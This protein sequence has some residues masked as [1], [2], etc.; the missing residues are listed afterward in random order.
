MADDI[1]TQCDGIVTSKCRNRR[2]TARAEALGRGAT[3]YQGP[4]CKWGHSGLRMVCNSGCIECARLRTSAWLERQKAEHPDKHKAR[5][6]AS[7]KRSYV[8]HPK[9]QTEKSKARE[10]AREAGETIFFCGACPVGHT[11]GWY[12][13]KGS[14]V[15]CERL[16]AK[17]K[18]PQ[19]REYLAANPDVYRHKNRTAL[20]RRRGAE[21]KHTKE[22]VAQILVAQKHKCANPMCRKSL[23]S[24]FDVD[25]I[26]PIAK[27]GT[28]W[29]R[30]LQLM[31]SPCNK[32]KNALLPTEWARREGFLL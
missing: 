3:T 8:P 20:A 21:G 13:K 1:D 32:R 31:C 28:N 12:V 27:G 9:P 30:N 25:H 4:P 29:P 15:T 5:V 19:F 10:R 17:Q 14:C 23:K 18:I 6:R 24:G 26:V 11:D 7:Y 2:I 16:A 22:D